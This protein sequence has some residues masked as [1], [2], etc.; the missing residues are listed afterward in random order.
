MGILNSKTRIV[1]VVMTPLGRASLSQG[2]LKVAY[3]SFTDGQAYYD[4]GS[5]SGSYDTAAD[6]I[7]LE[8]PPS[9]PQDTLAIVTDDSGR[10]IPADAF[11]TSLGSDGTVYVSGSGAVT[12]YQ[13]GNAFSSAVSNITNMF[14]TSFAY[15]TIIGSRSPLDNES[16]FEVSP[17]TASFYIPPTTSSLSVT[18][19]NTAD[20]IFFDRKFA[21]LPQF[22]FLPPV[23]QNAGKTQ[24][25]GN[26]RNAKQ[27]NSYPYETLKTEVFGTD[28]KPAKQRADIQFVK[29]SDSNDIVLQ[30]YEITNNGLTKLDAVDYGEVVDSSDKNHPRKRIVF[31]GKVFIDDTETPTYINLFTVVL[32]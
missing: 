29:T 21:N 24:N 30:M 2:G 25:L 11:G 7:Y 15:N 10:L 8:S 13:T 26:F 18:S 6:R 28:A 22:R 14:Q 27:F 12:G 32:D 1:D 16:T 17:T 3:A 5:V 31:F 4:P 9:L 20:S 23:V 19:I